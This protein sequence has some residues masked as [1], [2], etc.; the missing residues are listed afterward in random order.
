[1]DAGGFYQE[2]GAQLVYQRVRK[3]G[4]SYSLSVVE[5]FRVGGGT[6]PLWESHGHDRRVQRSWH[7]EVPESFAA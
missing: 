2:L 3:Q 7:I 6:T 5:F 4:Q 1:M